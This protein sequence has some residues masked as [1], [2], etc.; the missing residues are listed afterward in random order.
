MIDNGSESNPCRIILYWTKYF[1]WNDFGVGLGE[2]TFVNAKCEINVKNCCRTTTNRDLLNRSDAIIFHANNINP[3][4]LPPPSWRLPRQQF[5]FFNYESPLNTDLDKLRYHFKNGYFNKTMTYRRNSDIVSMQP[6]GRLKCINSS[7]STSSCVDFPLANEVQGNHQSDN[8]SMES[9]SVQIDLTHKNRT[10]AWFVSNCWTN[11][12]REYLVRNLSSYIVVDIY[13]DCHGGRKCQN[14]TSC[15]QML[16]RYYRFYL[17]FENSLCPDYITEKLYRALAHDTVPVVFGGADYSVYLP[18]GSYINA[19]DF[20]NPLQLANHLQKLMV[21]DD[22]YLKHF[23]WRGKY[24]VDTAP[25]QGWCQ[26]CHII[27]RKKEVYKSYTDIAAWWSGE[28]TNQSCFRPPASL[29]K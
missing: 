5:I 11:S 1:E 14:L 20:D 8:A 9:F 19:M 6:Y 7:T 23:Y 10:A 13:G 28:T 21:N 2:T 3:E 27:L 18:P 12:G 16:S 24:T 17:S 26:L 25:S 15:D 29:V 4:D 22:L